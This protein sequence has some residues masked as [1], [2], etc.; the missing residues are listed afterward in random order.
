MIRAFCKAAAA[1][2]FAA[3]LLL[4]LPARATLEVDPAVLYQKM[5]A[6]YEKGAAGGWTFRDQEYYL[7][8]IFD[9]G[10]AYS[11]Q[12]PDD[13]VY[14]Q[15]CTL[16]VDV[17]TGL[18]YDPLTN[19]DA[20]PWFVR[21]ASLYVIKNDPNPAEVAKAKALL[22]RANALE[23]P[24]ELAQLAD[25]DATANLQTY[26]R[27]PD[28]LLQRVEAEWRGWLITGDPSWRSLAFEHANEVY[29]PIAQLPTTWGPAFVDALKNAA[30]GVPG[31]T[32]GD[33]ANAQAIVARLERVDPLMIIGSVKSMPADKYLT[34][35]APADEYFGPLGMSILGIEN[36]LGRIHYFIVHGYA[37]RESTMAV[38]VAVA[39]DDLHKV[40]P[41]DRDLPK[42]LLESYRTLGQI[43]TKEAAA[44][45]AH[46]RGILTVEYQDTP[47]A[48]ELLR[49]KS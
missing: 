32:Q 45:Q 34:M 9:A 22:E 44:A 7:A 38:Q 25:Q 42:L 5:K 48:Q 47:Q 13:A 17:A 14:G 40:Y 12:R 41:R 18:H 8:T 21:E 49:Q 30:H 36:E 19:H 16:A 1:G 26:S 43:H 15:L 35:L 2:V 3:A 20:V 11:L 4:A 29:F 23:D 28:A 24:V 33:T 39:I 46:V 6:A 37:Q 27:D 31:Y 10:R